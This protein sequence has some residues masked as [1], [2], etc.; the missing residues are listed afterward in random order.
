MTEK[1]KKINHDTAAFLKQQMDEK[2]GRYLT[3]KMNRNEFLYNKGIL[4]DVNEKL[5]VHESGA[6][7]AR[8][9]TPSERQ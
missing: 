9:L 8:I 1:S 6:M 3:R 4:V 5:R 7:S 2:S